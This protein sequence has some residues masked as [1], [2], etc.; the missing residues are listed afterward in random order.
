MAGNG[1][2]EGE[3]GHSWEGEGGWLEVARKEEEEVKEEEVKVKEKKGG[4]GGGGR[5]GEKGI[6]GGKERDI[7]LEK[8]GVFNFNGYSW[9]GCAFGEWECAFLITQSRNNQLPNREMVNIDFFYSKVGKV[10]DK[11]VA[12]I[13][14]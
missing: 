14:L 4:G 10:K 9:K 2:R 13:S 7:S 8:I 11:P 1:E 5:E 12:I 6:L 3:E